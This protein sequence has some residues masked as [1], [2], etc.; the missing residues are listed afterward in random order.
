M[1]SSTAL[2]KHQ[3]Q[4]DA[5]FLFTTIKEVSFKIS[6]MRQIDDRVV[7]FG[8]KK[9]II[10]LKETRL[11]TKTVF[12]D[13]ADAI[14]QDSCNEE[15]LPFIKIIHKKNPQVDLNLTLGLLQM[16]TEARIGFANVQ[17]G[18]FITGI[19]T[20]SHIYTTFSNFD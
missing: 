2:C 13:A 4:E 1:S 19:R 8:P 14:N 16:K 11:L 10:Y 12:K 20:S 17:K 3:S 18:Y 7:N 5:Q 15:V 9:M 6:S